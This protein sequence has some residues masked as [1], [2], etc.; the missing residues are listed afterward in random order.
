MKRVATAGTHLAKWGLNEA[1]FEVYMTKCLQNLPQSS[2]NTSIMPKEEAHG[3]IPMY[4][5]IVATRRLPT[6]ILQG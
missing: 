6:L 1:L 2:V 4:G 3:Q 5:K